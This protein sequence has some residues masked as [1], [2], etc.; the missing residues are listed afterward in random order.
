MEE[1]LLPL[2]FESDCYGYE[3]NKEPFLSKSREDCILNFLKEKEYKKCK[4]NRQWLHEKYEFL[5]NKTRYESHN[6]SIQYNKEE[7]NRMCKKDC[8]TIRYTL[9]VKQSS[10]RGF[11]GS[12]GYIVPSSY[13]KIKVTHLPKMDLITY[14]CSIASLNGMWIGISIYST[15]GYLKQ[16]FDKYIGKFTIFRHL[17]NYLRIMNFR[18]FRKIMAHNRKSIIII[19]MV[20]MMIQIFGVIKNYL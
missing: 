16:L 11:N 13:N 20:L 17:S 15:L 1:I 6:C 4:F 8:K 14:L 18:K 5:P 10:T 12:G 19:C 7:L 3:Q 9:S 2:P